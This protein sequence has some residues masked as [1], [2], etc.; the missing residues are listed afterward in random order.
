MKSTQKRKRSLSSA[1]CRFC[2]KTLRRLNLCAVALCCLIVMGCDRYGQKPVC[3][4]IVDGKDLGN[5]YYG[6]SG[7][8]FDG[9][10]G[11]IWY[12]CAGGSY[13]SQN[14][15]PGDPLKLSW[16]DAVAY[17]AELSAVS[18]VEW[19]LATLPEVRSIISPSCIGPAVNPNVFPGMKSANVWTYSENSLQSDA[20]R[21]SVYTYNGAYSCRELKRIAKSFLLVHDPSDLLKGDSLRRSFFGGEGEALVPLDM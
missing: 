11:T 18:G 8:A 1:I 17:A 16:L 15:C 9:E 14:T 19:R 12:R 4:S 5:F 20:F 21:C 7:T 2:Y 6:P 13:F 10:T 3:S